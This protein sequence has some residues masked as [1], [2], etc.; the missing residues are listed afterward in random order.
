MME[1]SIGKLFK[2]LKKYKYTVGVKRVKA[3]LNKAKS[4]FP[5]DVVINGD[6]VDVMVAVSDWFIEYFG[7]E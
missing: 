5:I 1:I 4:E 2:G 7:E 3:W 6:Q